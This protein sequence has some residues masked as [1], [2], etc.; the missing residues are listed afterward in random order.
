LEACWNG[1]ENLKLGTS[2]VEWMKAEDSKIQSLKIQK[3][4][5][6]F[7]TAKTKVQKGTS[8]ESPPSLYHFRDNFS[9]DKTF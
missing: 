3:N 7:E 8:I 6:Q 2:N 5:S 4:E 9:A 1:V